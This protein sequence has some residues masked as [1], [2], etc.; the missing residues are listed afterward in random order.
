[1]SRLKHKF[2]KNFQDW[3]VKASKVDRDI[4]FFC[5][6]EEECMDQI[7]KRFTAEQVKVL[8]RGY[9]IGQ[10]LRRL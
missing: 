3:T 5:K 8:L 10:Q 6:N 4:T 9:W 7:H 2:S 1:L